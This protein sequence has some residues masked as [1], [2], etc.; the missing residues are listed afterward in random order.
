MI[1]VFVSI[2]MVQIIHITATIIQGT[3]Q[4]TGTSPVSCKKMPDTVRQRIA[5]TT[6]TAGLYLL[7]SKAT[8]IMQALHS[9]NAVYN[10]GISLIL[11][12]SVLTHVF[13]E[14]LH[15]FFPLLSAD[16]QFIS[17]YH[18]A[19]V[20]HSVNISHVHKIAFGN[21]VKSIGS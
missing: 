10:R 11:I 8:N 20:F 14:C 18:A 2:Y 6:V 21:S 7:L 9:A 3:H 5:K 1:S 19:S 16:L 15:K 13:Q 4:I 17:F 12:F